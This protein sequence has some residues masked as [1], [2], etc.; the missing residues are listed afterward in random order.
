[1]QND[2]I[3]QCHTYTLLEHPCW[4]WPPPPWTAHSK[5]GKEEAD[6]FNRGVLSSSIGISYVSDQKTT[7]VFS[8]SPCDHI[9]KWKNCCFL[10]FVYLR[11]SLCFCCSTEP[12]TQDARKKPKMKFRQSKSTKGIQKTSAWLT[13]KPEFPQ[14]HHFGPVNLLSANASVSLN[15]QLQLLL[16]PRKDRPAGVPFTPCALA[17][18]RPSHS[19]LWN[20][21]GLSKEAASHE[22]FRFLYNPKPWLHCPQLQAAL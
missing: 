11:C 18:F 8:F 19:G 14:L 6:C 10:H 13:V 1:M 17:P 3:S 20:P 4:R 16:S 2:H 15:C 12:Y 7:S 21:A 9:L 5:R 22:A